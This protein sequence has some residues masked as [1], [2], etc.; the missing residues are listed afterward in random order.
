MTGAYPLDVD[1]DGIMDVV[2]LR[3]GENIVMR[4]QGVTAALPVPTR[5]WGFARRR[6]AGPPRYAAT[7]EKGS[8]VAHYCHRQL[9]RPQPRS[10]RT[11]GLL[12]TTTVLQRP[13]GRART[14]DLPL[15]NAN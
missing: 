2:V 10:F 5:T 4:G 8:R 15:R 11:L 12:H 9:H 13:E 7:W 14:R 3:V 6:S 1:G